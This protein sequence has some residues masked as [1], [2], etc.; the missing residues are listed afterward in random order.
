MKK[1]QDG[2]HRAK[3][4]DGSGYAYGYY[5]NNGNFPNAPKGHYIKEFGQ[6]NHI[7]PIHIDTL[8][9]RLNGKWE[10]VE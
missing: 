8:R 1:I 4:M 5:R 7:T 6:N 2:V 9:Y 3:R 10:I